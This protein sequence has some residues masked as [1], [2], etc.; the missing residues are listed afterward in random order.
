M[1][2][3]VNFVLNVGFPLSDIVVDLAKKQGFLHSVY[4]VKPLC[5]CFSKSPASIVSFSFK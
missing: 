5:Q 4:L 1:R 3:Q 2:L